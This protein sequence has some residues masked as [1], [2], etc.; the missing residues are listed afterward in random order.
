MKNTKFEIKMNKVQRILKKKGLQVSRED[1]LYG[2]TGG[3]S[4]FEIA[5]CSDLE[6]PGV[7]F[8]C[9]CGQCEE[10]KYV[11]VSDHR[12][13]LLNGNPNSPDAYVRFNINDRPEQIAD[14]IIG[15]L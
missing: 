13:S 3:S 8:D 9:I 10:W 12:A 2:E 4:Y 6:E 11:R 7:P 14:W 1:W 15:T 5:L